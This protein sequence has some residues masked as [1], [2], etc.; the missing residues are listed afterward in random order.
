MDK[1]DKVLIA[2]AVVLG[3]AVVYGIMSLEKYISFSPH[4][5]WF[6]CSRYWAEQKDGVMKRYIDYMIRQTG[7]RTLKVDHQSPEQC[8]QHWKDVAVSQSMLQQEMQLGM[9]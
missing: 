7:V 9:V 8:R 3:I 2:V 6:D 4:K 1:T 5:D